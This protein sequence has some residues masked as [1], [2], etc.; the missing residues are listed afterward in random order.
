MVEGLCRWVGA[1][2]ESTKE[3]F[4]LP[5]I[6]V[7]RGHPIENPNF[8]IQGF[9]SCYLWRLFRHSVSNAA[10][11]VKMTV[12]QDCPIIKFVILP[13]AACSDYIL[14]PLLMLHTTDLKRTVSQDLPTTLPSMFSSIATGAILRRYHQPLLMLH[15][16]K[17]DRVTRFYNYFPP[18]NFILLQAPSLDC[19]VTPFSNAAQPCHKISL[20]GF[21]GTHVPLFDTAKLWDGPCQYSNITV[22]FFW[23]LN[24]HLKI[25]KS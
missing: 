22:L 19:S 2:K 10:Q 20:Q 25:C 4:P 24:F 23:V 3:T 7:S 18:R 6:K 9:L 15:N 14:Q 17:K 8:P 13:P 12:S 1:S 5:A 11:L 16:F 21:W